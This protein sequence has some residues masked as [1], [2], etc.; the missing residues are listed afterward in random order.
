MN[1]FNDL[2]GEFI[3]K[4]RLSNKMSGRFMLYGSGLDEIEST[5]FVKKLDQGDIDSSL[6][7]RSPDDNEINATIDIKYRGNDELESVIQAIAGINLEASIE[8]RQ[9]N[10]MFGKFELHEAPRIETRLEP[11]ADATTRSRSDL[12]TINYGDTNSMLIGKNM[13]EFFESFIKFGELVDRIPDLKILES[14][15]LR[16]YYIESP[17]G[18]QIELHQPNTIWHE[19]GV[20]Y[21]NRPYSTELL[22]NIYT[23]NTVERYIEFDVLDA[24]SKWKSADLLNYGFIVQTSD[25]R[26]ISFYTR[27]TSK[28]PLLIV[29]YITSKIYSIGRELIDSTIFVHGKGYKDINGLITVNSTVGLEYFKSTLYVHR[30]EDPMFSEKE[31]I[32]AATR[33]DVNSSLTVAIR[34]EDEFEGLITVYE[35][36][37]SPLKSDI[38]IS[39]P[40]VAAM[41]T[42][43]PNISLE[44]S[45]TVMQT[46]D[47]CLASE[48][49]VNNPDLYGMIAVDP[50]ISLAAMITIGKNEEDPLE[51]IIA[52]SRREIDTC[53]K[54]RAL[55]EDYLDS[56]IEVPYYEN[57]E[58]IMA[59]SRREIDAFIEVREYN[60]IDGELWVKDREFLDSTIDVKQ[61]SELESIITV[62]EFEE[63]ENEIIINRPELLSYIQ[64]RVIGYEDLE[65]IANIRKRDASD[66]DSF[67]HVRGSSNSSYWFIM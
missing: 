42:I 52:I 12:Q 7:V 21:A 1:D 46:D 45:I 43:D 24:A 28:S 19:Y 31:A 29:K 60:Q 61:I 34:E 27:E 40:D 41:L 50:N 9:H 38:T 35:S 17:Q 62:R 53:I 67:L 48:I 13:T 6:S 11:V 25:N 56:L 5:I 2:N 10:R 32:I 18:T 54:V 57:L 26:T 49:V 47:D 30:S 16:L 58:T 3:I 22:S 59:V 64:P 37:E 65:I 15:K 14:V 44:S 55:G 23:I 33:P 66:I 20:T 4:S 36:M 63:L 51:T 39:T 8:V